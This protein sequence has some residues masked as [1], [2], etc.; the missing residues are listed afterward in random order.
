MTENKDKLIVKKE[1]YDELVQNGPHKFKLM[2]DPAAYARDAMRNIEKQLQ[3]AKSSRRIQK[4]LARYNSWKSE[5]DIL[6]SFEQNKEIDN[7]AKND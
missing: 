5:V 1:L 7:N 3:N 2:F 6:E 4:L